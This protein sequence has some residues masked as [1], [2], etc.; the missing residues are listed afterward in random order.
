LAALVWR[1]EPA[2]PPV[3]ASLDDLAGT[4]AESKALSSELRRNGFG[5]VGPTTVYSAMQALGVVNDH[6]RGCAFRRRV[7]DERNGFAPPSDNA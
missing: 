3:P 6:L 7:D 4:T 5:F 2:G 1:Y